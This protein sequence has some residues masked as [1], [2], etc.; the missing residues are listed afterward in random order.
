MDTI[1]EQA[2]PDPTGNKGK[3]NIVKKYLAILATAVLAANVAF[4]ADA[5]KIGVIDMAR[6]VKAHPDTPTADSQLEKQLEE[7]QTE[8]KDM[9]SEYDKLKGDFEDARKDA[10]DKALS[11]DARE[12]KMKIA[13]ER[14][15]A[16]RDYE[17]KIR[18]TMGLR[19]KQLQEQSMHMRKRIIDKI[20]RMIEDYSADKGYGLVLDKAGLSVN[21]VE[22]VLYSSDKVDITE[23]IYKIVSKAK[24]SL[25]ADEEK[26]SDKKD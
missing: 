9:E 7:Y 10:A 21:G 26:K 19:Q 17:R 13:E 8:Q 2:R 6:I 16:V 3:V 25:S 18:E 22:I 4:C 14:L 12:A 1:T 5:V 20:R 11:D 23:D 15:T 24:P